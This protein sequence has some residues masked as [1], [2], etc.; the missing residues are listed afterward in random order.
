MVSMAYT[1]DV[2]VPVNSAPPV[3]VA[4][5]PLVGIDM[6]DCIT[7]LYSVFDWVAVAAEAENLLASEGE[8]P[9]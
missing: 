6:A 8:H 7:P 5:G 9:R 2:Q 1:G 3:K 4:T